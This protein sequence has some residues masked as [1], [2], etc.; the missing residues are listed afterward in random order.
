MEWFLRRACIQ[1]LARCPGG[2]D[3]R[4]WRAG[5][6]ADRGRS[7][8]RPRRSEALRRVRRTGPIG[9]GRLAGVDGAT[10]WPLL[11]LAGW[12]WRIRRRGADGA[13]TG[14]AARP[15]HGGFGDDHGGRQ[16]TLGETDLGDVRRR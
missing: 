5:L 7:A 9:G 10:A 13:W 12:H 6:A 1:R 8:G 16:G 4:L 2:N 3:A 11:G 15:D 14:W